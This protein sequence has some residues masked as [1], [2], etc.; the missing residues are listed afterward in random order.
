VVSQLGPESFRPAPRVAS[1][2]LVLEKQESVRSDLV[3]EEAFGRALRGAFGTRRKTLRKSLRVNLGLE[4]EAAVAVLR[5]AGLDGQRRGETL[6]LDE[7]V[8]LAN[9]LAKLG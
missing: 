8:T 9:T 5:E 2:A 1:T 3:S 4:A 6:S 7:L